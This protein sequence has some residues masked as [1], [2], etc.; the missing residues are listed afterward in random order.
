[1]KLVVEARRCGLRE[2]VEESSEEG[3]LGFDTSV[4]PDVKLQVTISSCDPSRLLG[5]L[6]ELSC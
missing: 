5:T 3:G 2:E 4:V 1:M 6:L